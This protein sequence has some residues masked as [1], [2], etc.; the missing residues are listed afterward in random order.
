M[1][2]ALACT[3]NWGDCVG[4]LAQV[5]LNG[6]APREMMKDVHYADWAPD[7]ET[8]AVVRAARGRICLEYPLGKLLYETPGWITYLR[9]SPK[10]DLIA[11]LDHPILA[12]IGGSVCV[13]DL[14]GKKRI[15]STGWKG[16][17]GLAWSATGDEIWF[18]G[19]RVSKR[20]R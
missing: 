2:I 11:F 19:S 15:L 10:G 8:L 13:V 1:A 12:D 4:T 7:G 16:L 17:H 5:S 9:V 14:A 20:R 3:L 6:G 18:S